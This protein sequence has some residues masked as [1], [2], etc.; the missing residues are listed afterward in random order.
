M[1]KHCLIQRMLYLHQNS[2]MKK[3]LIL[4]GA[5]WVAGAAQA[6]NWKVDASHSNVKFSITHLMVSEVEGNFRV[7]D[8]SI[9][10]SKEDFTDADIQF[11][12]DVNSINTDNN[13]RDEHLK[14]DDFF[15]A[16]TFP[17]MTFKST[18]FKKTGDK[19]YVLEGNLTIRDVTKPVSF[20][21]NY[22]GQTKDPWGNT[23]AGFKA[24]S[25]IKRQDYKLT[26][27][28]LTE[29]GG[30]V[31]SNEVEIKLNL[32]FDLKK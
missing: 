9:S 24:S 3:I 25:T 12:V 32:E 7:Y 16:A 22:Y 17:K 18:S 8:G 28:K 10:A 4:F 1:F 23:K 30:A 26:W 19:Q 21:V 5:L 11:S 13:S 31:V 20:K 14:G 29:A 15:N 6:A 27:N 2:L